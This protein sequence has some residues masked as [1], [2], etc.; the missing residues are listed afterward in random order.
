MEGTRGR[1]ICN[2]LKKVKAPGA[3]SS[4]H[5]ENIALNGAGAIISRVQP[6]F[7]QLNNSPRR[8]LEEQRRILNQEL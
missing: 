7:R 5:E 1:I 2:G 3:L 6:T 4:S 8:G